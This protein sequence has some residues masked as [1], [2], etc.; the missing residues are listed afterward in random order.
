MPSAEYLRGLEQTFGGSALRLGY[1]PS[2]DDEPPPM[3]PSRPPEPLKVIK[4]LPINVH[5][6]GKRADPVDWDAVD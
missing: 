3:G 5:R 2:A 4:R 6:V 1:K